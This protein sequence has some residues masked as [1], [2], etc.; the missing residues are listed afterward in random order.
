MTQP[1]PLLLL[2]GLVVSVMGY[3]WLLG[4]APAQPRVGGADGAGG[5]ADRRRGGAGLR[6]GAGHAFQRRDLAYLLVACALGLGYFLY[7]DFVIVWFGNLP[8]H[9]GW[10]VDAAPSRRRCCPRLALRSGCSCRS[11]WS[12][13]GA[14]S[15]RGAGPGGRR[16]SRSGSIAV[17]IVAGPGGWIGLG[18]ALGAVLAVGGLARERVGM[19]QDYEG[20][21]VPR[22]PR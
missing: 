7:I 18:V 19:S 2:H 17:W 20:W 16:W 3:D 11:C 22:G 5:D 12:A 9:V 1:G 13:W 6:G 14:T 8:A 15:G 21:S 10:Y 4:V